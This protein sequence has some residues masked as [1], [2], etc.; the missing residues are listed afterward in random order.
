MS[1]AKLSKQLQ[2]E[3]KANP[4][5]AGA[6]GLL[7]LVAAWFWGPLIFKS[8][9]K[10]P[11][12]V[13][14]APTATTAAA[15]TATPDATAVSTAKP[16]MD[17][18]TLSSRLEADPSMRSVAGKN[19]EEVERS[20]FDAPIKIAK[21]DPIDQDLYDLLEEASA[22]GMLDERP[23]I[24]KQMTSTAL[25]ACPLR[26]TSTLVG[27]RARTAVIN[28]QA[29]SQ[30]MVLGK[31]NGVE[32]VLEYVGERS[33]MIAWNGMKRELRIPKPGEKPQDPLPDESELT[34]VKD[35]RQA[36]E[37]ETTGEAADALLDLANEQGKPTN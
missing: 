34:G 31:F 12:P 30:G 4:Q 3:L 29:F 33:A 27:P 5:K 25:N 20:P 19:D 13:A 6:L 7:C 32:L 9:P 21:E 16:L 1:A 23:V 8:D 26:L 10:K 2:R 37:T 17:W 36:S 14:A 11:A 35:T 28:G 15:T 24:T 18:R 22:A